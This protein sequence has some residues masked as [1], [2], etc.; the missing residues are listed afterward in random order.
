MNDYER[1]AALLAGEKRTQDALVRA[2]ASATP[3][4][5]RAVWTALGQYIDNNDPE[6]CA[7]AVGRQWSDPQLWE[8]AQSLQERLDEAMA[9]LAEA[10]AAVAS[11]G[12]EALRELDALQRGP[13][14]D[15]YTPE[16]KLDD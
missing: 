12:P 13:L 5:A 4:E 1:H 2:L 7:D 16:S 10:D 8:A 3:E 11:L 14:G 9:I 15:D 6:E